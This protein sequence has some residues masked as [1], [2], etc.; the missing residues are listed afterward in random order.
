M[1]RALL[2]LLLA[3]ALCGY[4]YWV[5]TRA[6]LPVRG[7]RYLAALRA[8]TLVLLLALIFD[9]RLPSGGAGSSHT[10]WVL[11][12]VSRSMSAGDGL[13]WS[14]ALDR[15]RS[16]ADDGWTVVSFGDAV[17]PA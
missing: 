7:G 2:F 15:A 4:A 8:V 14:R 5:Y 9:P 13:A 1:I 12:D 3:G 17:A 10:R 16:L 11:L 6:E